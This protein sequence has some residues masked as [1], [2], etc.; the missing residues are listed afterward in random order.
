M[1]VFFLRERERA[2]EWLQQGRVGNV[3]KLSHWSY[4]GGPQLDGLLFQWATPVRARESK[5]HFSY[6]APCG[7]LGWVARGERYVWPR[8]RHQIQTR[9]STGAGSSCTAGRPREPPQHRGRDNWKKRWSAAAA[10][11]SAKSRR[12]AAVQGKM[13]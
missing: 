4:G 11:R 1:L 3:A 9:G 12:P 8:C 5:A 10:A 6:T 13:R 7:L 2:R